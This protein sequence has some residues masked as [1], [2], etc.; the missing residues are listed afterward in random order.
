LELLGT[1]NDI[2]ESFADPLQNEQLLHTKIV[3]EEDHLDELGGVEDSMDRRCCLGD[4]LL[5]PLA[6]S[7]G[8]GGA[9]LSRPTYIL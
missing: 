4:I 1:F 5:R 7:Q 8:S 3:I 6:E 9:T 2:L